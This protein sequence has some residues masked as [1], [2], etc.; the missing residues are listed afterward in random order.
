[1]ALSPMC[2]NQSGTNYVARNLFVIEPISV[3]TMKYVSQKR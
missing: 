3:A 1:M 2:L